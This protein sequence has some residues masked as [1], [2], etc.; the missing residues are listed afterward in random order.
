[1]EYGKDLDPPIV[2]SHPQWSQGGATFK[3]NKSGTIKIYIK[4]AE[5][6]L[7]RRKSHHYP[8]IWRPRRGYSNQKPRHAVELSLLNLS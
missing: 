5:A 2:S 3:I 7:K 4:S 6:E 1:V 8:F